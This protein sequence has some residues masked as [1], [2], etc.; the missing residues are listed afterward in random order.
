M[1]HL[2]QLH[3]KDLPF[4]QLPNPSADVQ[5]KAKKH[6]DPWQVIYS[7]FILKTALSK[8][9]NIPRSQIKI[10]TDEH[11]KPHLPNDERYFNLSHTKD[12]IVLATDDQ[13]IGIDAELIV[14]F[15]EV[16]DLK[17]TLSSQEREQF[18]HIPKKHQL[19]FFYKLWTL[20]ESYLKA[21]GK[22][23]SISLD[24]FTIALSEQA[25]LKSAPDDDLDW[26]LKLYTPA[27]N[28][29]CAVCSRNKDFP[30]LE[31]LQIT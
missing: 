20:K 12:L 9:L 27:S 19:H 8:E 6:K 10:L 2:Y 22:G 30:Q 23:L 16:E 26:H 14:P 15:D 25:I 17:N 24:S 29:I 18:Q 28:Y 1:I 31:K 7:D 13:P 4:E 11:G 5:A 21:I 3:K